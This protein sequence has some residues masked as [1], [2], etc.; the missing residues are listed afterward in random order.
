MGCIEDTLQTNDVLERLVL[1]Q[2]E[3]RSTDFGT[4][5][6]IIALPVNTTLKHLSLGQCRLG[7]A[8]M[9]EL[10]KALTSNKTLTSLSLRGNQCGPEAM[11]ALGMVLSAGVT[12]LRHLNLSSCHIEDDAG[13]E[14]AGGLATNTTLETLHLR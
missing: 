7:T 10:A 2:N 8:G 9:V 12:A 6:L 5:S 4:K 3:H 13:V 14:L 11:A 1:D